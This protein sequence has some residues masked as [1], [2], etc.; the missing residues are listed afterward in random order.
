MPSSPGYK[1]NY[2]QERL[3]ESSERKEQRA[4][5]NRARRQLMKEGLVK[6]GD[7][8]HVNHKQPLSKGGSNSRSNLSVKSAASNVSYPR[9]RTGAMRGRSKR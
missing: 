6:V 4:A 9:T 7:S 1:R 2:K 3:A 5:R 8:K